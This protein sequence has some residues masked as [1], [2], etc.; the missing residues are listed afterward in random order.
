[1]KE[2]I[3][4]GKEIQ[5]LKLRYKFCENVESCIKTKLKTPIQ[6]KL[7]FQKRAFLCVYIFE[8][9]IYIL[10]FSKLSSY[11]VL[12]DYKILQAGFSDSDIQ[13]FELQSRIWVPL[14]HQHLPLEEETC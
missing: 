2:K 6:N 14:S 7:Y 11:K 13:C 10:L 8:Y 5:V 3:C 4:M 1:M 9:Q 12:S